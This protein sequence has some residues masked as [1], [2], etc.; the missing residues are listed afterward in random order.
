[1]LTGLI[2]SLATK[3]FH[4]QMWLP[5]ILSINLEAFEALCGSFA[6]PQLRFQLFMSK[7]VT[8]V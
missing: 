4:S 8:G 1:M 6:G 3:D 7:K 5:S 2:I